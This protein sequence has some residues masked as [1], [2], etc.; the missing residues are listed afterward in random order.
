[1]IASFAQTPSRLRSDKRSSTAHL[2][3]YLCVR[4]TVLAQRI[5]YICGGKQEEG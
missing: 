4:Y 1:M 5:L 2:T 3:T